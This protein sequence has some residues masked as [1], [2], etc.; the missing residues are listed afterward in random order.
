MNIGGAEPKNK[1][2]FKKKKKALKSTLGFLN[3]SSHS[4]SNN[5]ARI[6]LLKKK[7]EFPLE[8]QTPNS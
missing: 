4:Y 3:I 6:S 8:V 7:H 1:K 5:K 2:Y